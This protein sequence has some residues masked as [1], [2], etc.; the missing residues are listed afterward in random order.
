MG[1][2][3]QLSAKGVNF[4]IAGFGQ[5]FLSLPFLMKLRPKYIKLASELIE[6]CADDEILNNVVKLMQLYRD[7]DI[8]IIANG[9]YSEAEFERLKPLADAFQG[10]WISEQVRN[11]K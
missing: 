10:Y 4:A 11:L 5:D 8:K 7:L 1:H 9:I 3:D 6:S 2:Y